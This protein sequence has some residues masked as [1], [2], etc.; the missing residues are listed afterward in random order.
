MTRQILPT[1]RPA[2]RPAVPAS[3]R[4]VAAAAL[5]VLALSACSAADRVANIGEAPALTPIVNP[6][7]RDD[8]LAAVRRVSH[9]GFASGVVYDALHICCAERI[10]VDR[11]LTS[12]LAAFE[13]LRPAGIVVA[14]P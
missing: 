11:I 12:N 1:P 6:L 13:R 10:P 8:Y 7:T 14:A 9:E 2:F 5:T 3:G 4:R